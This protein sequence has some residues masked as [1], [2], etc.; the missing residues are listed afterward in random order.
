MPLIPATD[1][2]TPTNQIFEAN[3]DIETIHG[4]YPK[5]SLFR[6]IF[7]SPD[8][9]Y[10]H[11]EDAEPAEGSFPHQIYIET[12][13]LDPAK[14]KPVA[15]TAPTEMTVPDVR[16]SDEIPADD[17]QFTVAPAVIDGPVQAV[18]VEA[19]EDAPEA[20]LEPVEVKPAPKKRAPRKSKSTS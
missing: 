16:W 10:S 15:S 3:A 8:K 18:V 5:G 12:R 7:Q 20:I 11:V 2:S 13:L 9:S 19:P 14:R 17:V 4:V 6:M 1:N